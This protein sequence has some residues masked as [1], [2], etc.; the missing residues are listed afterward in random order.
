MIERPTLQISIGNKQY[1][2]LF[3]TGSLLTWISEYGNDNTIIYKG[4]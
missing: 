4:M 2:L 3:D 1:T